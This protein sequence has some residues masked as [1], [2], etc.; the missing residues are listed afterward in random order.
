MDLPDADHRTHLRLIH[1]LSASLRRWNDRFDEEVRKTS[2]RPAR[3]EYEVSQVID[4][5]YHAGF[6]DLARSHAFA[7]TIAAFLESLFKTNLP[8]VGHR[9]EIAI[10]SRNERL[11]TLGGNRDLFWNPSMPKGRPGIAKNIQQILAIT[12]LSGCFGADFGR[13][14]EA[15]FD[16]RNQMVHNGF[17]WPLEIRL[18][19]NRHVESG[20]RSRWFSTSKSGELPWFFTITPEFHETCLLTCDRA[21]LA[22]EGLV[23]G[24]W[25]LYEH[26][27][28]PRPK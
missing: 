26:K 21:V 10:P 11:V 6:A 25:E 18:E 17:E 5:F 9:G 8:A 12:G 4:I 24:D 19:F 15:I 7:C 28:G 2:E 14:A 22:F 20:E 27:F 13:I 3:D 16:Y 1:S 23:V